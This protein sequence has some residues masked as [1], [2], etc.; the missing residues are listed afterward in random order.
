MQ[1]EHEMNEERQEPELPP[2]QEKEHYTPRPKWQV[3]MAWVLLAIVLIGVI[4]YYMQIAHR[5]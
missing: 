4:L 2:L 1:T 3:Y 5:Y